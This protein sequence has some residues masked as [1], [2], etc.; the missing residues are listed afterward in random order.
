MAE[1]IR[2]RNPVHVLRALGLSQEM[3]EAHVHRPSNVAE[4]VRTPT[5]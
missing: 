5:V 1:V 2:N 3:V 4:A